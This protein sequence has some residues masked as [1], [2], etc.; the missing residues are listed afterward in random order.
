MP[1]LAPCASSGRA[2]R[3]WA[4][5]HFQEEAES[6]GAQ[7]LPQVL[8]L[9][10]SK[11]A[12]FTAFDHAGATQ[13]GLLAFAPHVE[14]GR[15]PVL[16]HEGCHERGGRHT[17]DRRLARSTLVR[18]YP[19]VSYALLEEEEDPL[20]GDGD[21]AWSKCLLRSAPARLRCLLRARLAALAVS[22]LRGRGW[23]DGRPATVSGA[24][25]SR[26]QSRR[27]HRLYD[28]SGAAREPWEAL[29]RRG[30]GFVDW[31]MARPEQHVAVAAHSQS[32]C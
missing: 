22:A 26:L 7:P 31:L 5:R 23:A 16:A 12:D 9:A 3:L 19:T 14:A 13:T 21:A 18:A 29:A 25:A 10:A 15:L 27:F 2:W 24:L 11:V 4:A 30:V 28:H 17:C 20:W 32:S 1:E 8:E 6:L